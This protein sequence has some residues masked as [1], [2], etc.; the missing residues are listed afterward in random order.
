M[1]LASKRESSCCACSGSSSA[2][3]GA[4]PPFRISRPSSR[5]HVF[6][7]HRPGERKNK[8]RK[9]EGGLVKCVILQ[10]QPLSVPRLR[11]GLT[12]IGGNG[13]RTKDER[14][15]SP[16]DQLDRGNG[17]GSLGYSVGMRTLSTA[18]PERRDGIRSGP[19]NPP[20]P[21][22]SLSDTD[23]NLGT[24]NYVLTEFSVQAAACGPGPVRDP[25]SD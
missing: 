12:L 8:A 17:C 4:W 22:L 10:F 11:N 2:L 6:S 13:R 18:A 25:L 24:P 5:G 20:T 16:C 19:P 14:N 3:A 23:R 1:A 9:G 15:P 21:P 7:E